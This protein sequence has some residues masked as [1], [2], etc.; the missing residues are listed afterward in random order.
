MSTFESLFRTGLRDFQELDIE[1]H[2]E[3]TTYNTVRLDFSEARDFSSLEEFKR[4]FFDVLSERFSFAGFQPETKDVDM[5]VQI[6]HWMA[7]QPTSSLVLLIDEYDAPLTACLHN[8]KRKLPIDLQAQK[9]GT[10]K[11]GPA[12]RQPRFFVGLSAGGY[13]SGFAAL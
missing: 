11:R 6:G 4:L 9:E 5:T 10:K 2:W 13:A 8:P 3:D 7:R 1:K 12:C